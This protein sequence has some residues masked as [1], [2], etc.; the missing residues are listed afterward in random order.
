MAART[1]QAPAWHAERCRLVGVA[2]RMT[3]SALDAEEVVQE[4]F[5]RLHRTAG[6]QNTAGWLTTVVI[7]LCLDR[8]RSARAQREACA[9]LWPPA[10]ACALAGPDQMVAQAELVS[11]AFMVV[12]G[13][14][15][16]LERIVFVLR[17]AFGFDY[18]AIA[19][20]VGRDPPA[21][22]Q[23]A[24]RARSHIRQRRPPAAR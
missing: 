11:A 13:T 1:Q 7:R 20:M 6:V 4:A 17:E 22:R 18:R 14:L 9:G 10:P 3:G 23:L 15:S 5:L 2:R 12:L 16:P 21:V 19:A 24:G 8:L